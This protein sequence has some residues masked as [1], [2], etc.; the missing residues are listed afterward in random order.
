MMEFAFLQE[1]ICCTA[2]AFMIDLGLDDW[3]VEGADQVA[4]AE[5]LEL[6]CKEHLSHFLQ[7]AE[8]EL[9]WKVPA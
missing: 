3:N 5:C 6:L 8:F 1:G 2:L 7:S 4:D 9:Q